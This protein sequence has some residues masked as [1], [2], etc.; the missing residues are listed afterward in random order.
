MPALASLTDYERAAHEALP[1]M[2][3]EYLCGGAGDECTLRANSD[4]WNALLL[5]TRALIDVGAI[6]TRT[7]LLGRAHAHPILLAP[8]AY[9]RLF[10][11]DGECATA[12]GASAANTTFVLSSFSTTSL[13]DVAQQATVPFWFQ[14][15]ISPDR[16]FAEALVR[17]AEDA[18]C[19]AICLTV[20]TPVLGARH[21]ETRIG[22]TLPDGLTRVNLEGMAH[23]PANTSHRP[24]DGAIYD[25]EWLRRIARVPILLKGIMDPDDARR[26]VETGVDGLIVSNHGARNLDTVPPTVTAL[27]HVIHAVDGRLP[28]L[29]DGGIRRGTDV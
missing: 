21:R 29:V 2:A 15:Y 13:D 8:T 16:G 22:F 12:R 20:D 19:E 23:A 1:S 24:P 10:T 3:W 4:A 28:V 18:G 17:R 11:P 27:P 6:D 25:V 5:R 9:Q 26:A 7:T 14:L